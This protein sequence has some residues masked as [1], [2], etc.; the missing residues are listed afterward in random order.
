MKKRCRLG[1]L[2]PLSTYWLHSL[3]VILSH[4]GKKNARAI[5]DLWWCSGVGRGT[6]AACLLIVDGEQSLAN[7]LFQKLHVLHLASILHDRF[8]YSLTANN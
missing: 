3:E 1:S 4:V 5:L 6:M 8:I 7:G 2:S